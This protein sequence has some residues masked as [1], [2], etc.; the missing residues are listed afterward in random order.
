MKVMSEKQINIT[1][2]LGAEVDVD[3]GDG[4][5]VLAAFPLFIVLFIT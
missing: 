3:Y 4:P 2:V 1:S 5:F